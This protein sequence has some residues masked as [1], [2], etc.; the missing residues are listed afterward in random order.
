MVI[1]H[2]M[3]SFMNKTIFYFDNLPNKISGVVSSLKCKILSTMGE[4]GEVL[5]NLEIVAS[6]PGTVAVGV[7]N[8]KEGKYSANYPISLDCIEFS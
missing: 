4:Q 5:Q 8:L 3:Y 6:P 2:K 1:A 7:N